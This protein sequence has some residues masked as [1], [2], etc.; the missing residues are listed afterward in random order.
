MAG[1]TIARGLTKYIFPSIEESIEKTDYKLVDT[2]GSKYSKW[3]AMKRKSGGRVNH[4]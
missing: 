3:K 2:Y 4:G 1:K